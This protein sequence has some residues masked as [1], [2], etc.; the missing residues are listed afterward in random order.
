MDLGLSELKTRPVLGKLAQAG[1]QTPR[2]DPKPR[3]VTPPLCASD[4]CPNPLQ[5]SG[6]ALASEFL[7]PIAGGR[8]GPH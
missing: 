1:Q 7:L 2:R 5:A 4:G 6:R 8:E 3:W